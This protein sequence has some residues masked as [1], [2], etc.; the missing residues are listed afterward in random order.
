MYY[1]YIGTLSFIMKGLKKFGYEA[2]RPGQEHAVKRILAGKD[3]SQLYLI[4]VRILMFK[5]QLGMIY[6]IK[7]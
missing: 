6:L 1:Y 2:F 5:N 3:V 7:I 4:M